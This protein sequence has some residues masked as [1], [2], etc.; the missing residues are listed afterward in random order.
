MSL[1]IGRVCGAASGFNILSIGVGIAV[2]TVI[3]AILDGTKNLWPFTI[4]IYWV[5]GAIP[6][7]LGVLLGAFWRARSVKRF[8]K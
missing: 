2:G 8:A 6:V 4:V 1:L 7:T 5:I 3:G